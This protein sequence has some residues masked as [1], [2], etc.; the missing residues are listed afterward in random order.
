MVQDEPS[1]TW[2]APSI[3]PK[4]QKYMHVYAYRKNMDSSLS[5]VVSGVTE[6]GHMSGQ[7]FLTLKSFLPCSLV[8]GQ[9]RIWQLSQCAC[10]S[11]LIAALVSCSL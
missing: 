7:Y 11:L 5:T 6:K 3:P 8:A 1:A 2:Q 4:G 10:P 9:T